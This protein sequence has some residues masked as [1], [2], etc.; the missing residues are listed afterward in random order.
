MQRKLSQSS[1]PPNPLYII[2]PL[3]EKSGFNL[4]HHSY[5]CINKFFVG[6]FTCYLAILT[7]KLSTCTLVETRETIENYIR[8]PQFFLADSAMILIIICK[9]EHPVFALA[10]YTQFTNVIVPEKRD[11]NEANF[12][13]RYNYKPFKNVCHIETNVNF[14]LHWTITLD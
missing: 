4:A 10:K 12:I 2:Y 6:Y 5:F 13:L 7:L 14:K 8:T 9:E 1:L 11:L 3:L